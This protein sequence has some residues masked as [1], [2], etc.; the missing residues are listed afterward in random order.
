MANASG[1]RAGAA[2]VE[3]FVKN[4]QFVKGLNAASAK[5]KAFGS[6]IQSL[7]SKLT[8]IGAGLAGGLFGAAKV[9]AEMGDDMAK[10][11]ART[12]VSVEALSE[13]RYAAQQSGAEAE[14]LEKGLRT[15]SR[16]IIEAASGSAS[17]Q[18]NFAKLGLTLADLNRLSPDEQFELIADRLSR[19]QNPASRA[20]LAMEIFGRTG[21][22]LLP[23]L[24]AGAEG[25]R[26]LRQEANNLGLTMS[27]EDAQAAEAFGDALDRLWQSLKRV[28][29][30][31]GASLAPT[32]QN[33]ADWIT[34]VAATVGSWI[35]ANREVIV[36][37]GSVVAGIIG[38]GAA[39]MTV[40][41]IISAIGI[42]LGVVAT[43]ISTAAS[44][45]GLLGSAFAFLL[46]PIGAVIATTV[47]IGAAVLF[48]TD[49]GIAALETL[50]QGF[51]DLL[52][53]AETAWQGIQDAIAAGD[54]AGAMEVAWLGIQAVWESAIATLS[55]SWRSFKSFF[56]EV[57]WSAVFLAAKAFDAAWTAIETTFWTVVDALDSGW[58]YFVAG[59]KIAFNEFVAFFK[60]AWARVRNIFNREAADREV[61]AINAEVQKQNKEALQQ[62]DK[63]VREDTFGRRA[64]AAQ[65]AGAQRSKVLDQ[66]QE[67]GRRDRQRQIEEA[68]K[69]DQAR[70]E[71]IKKALDAKTAALAAQR[72][73]VEMKREQDR[74]AREREQ[75]QRKE[76]E[77]SKFELPEFDL[78]SIE[79]GLDTAA[80]KTDVKGTFSAFAVAGLGSDSLA[81]RTAAAS[82]EVARNTEQLVRM[83]RNGGL[84]F[85]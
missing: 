15:M 18:Q 47:G 23:M 40:G 57:F 82:E 42:G 34:A 79:S 32:L 1:I 60:R 55:A 68:N 76:R 56:V 58:A 21:A 20:T 43:T 16:T 63:R 53:T 54:L 31:V 45:I 48:A 83:A 11:A 35:N 24:S 44:A 67:E 27:T 17:A 65:D 61:A 81:A 26:E 19:I 5:L 6:S 33:I 3:L 22:K 84:V 70:V 80:A 64:A 9:F 39:L 69:A 4:S 66:M 7:G 74:L 46:S 50:G 71:A 30:M 85:A 52:G 29:F 25:I 38:V 37:I 41:S 75:E 8:G 13:L 72:Q 62:L 2:Y 59:L 14:D 77:R 10:M 28:V 12:G 49:E 78:A 73:E 51:T 36:V